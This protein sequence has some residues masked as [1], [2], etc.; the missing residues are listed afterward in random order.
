MS[1]LE[2]PKAVERNFQNVNRHSVLSLL[3]PHVPCESLHFQPE[4]TFSYV[5]MY[6]RET[7][8]SMQALFV[9]EK[10]SCII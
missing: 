9:L 8:F 2:I 1:S 6:E 4:D 5:Y 7:R 10:Q 3:Q